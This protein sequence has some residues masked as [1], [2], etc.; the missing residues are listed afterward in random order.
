MAGYQ[1]TIKNSEETIEI[2]TKDSTDSDITSLSFKMKTINDNTKSRADCVKGELV[3]KGYITSENKDKTKRLAKWSIDSDQK[4]MYRDVE[5]VVY[6]SENCTGDVLRRFQ[7]DSMFVVD[8]L[9]EFGE[10]SRDE[11]GTYTLLIAQKEGK[12]NKEIFS[13]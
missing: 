4:T 8:Y 2:F 3:I 10:L 13:S 12:R 6:T 5:I 1:L 9:E 7:M 11:K